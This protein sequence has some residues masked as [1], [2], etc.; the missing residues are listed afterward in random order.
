MKERIPILLFLVALL[1]ALSG[2][3]GPKPELQSFDSKPPPQGS[4]QP[5]KVEAVVQNQSTGEGQVAVQVSLVNKQDGRVIVKDEKDV[6]MKS[7]E[8]QHVPFSI[9]L[10]ESAKDLDPKN[11][12]VQVEAHYPIE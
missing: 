10:P 8:I 11:I 4:D 12:D 5:F 7:N 2:C 3:L 9:D 1:F 6:D